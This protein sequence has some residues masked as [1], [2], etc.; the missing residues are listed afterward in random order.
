M[1]CANPVIMTL[2]TYHNGGDAFILLKQFVAEC[3]AVDIS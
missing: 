1:F 3:F 2:W